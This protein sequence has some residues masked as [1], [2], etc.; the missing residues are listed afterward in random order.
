MEQ[1]PGTDLLL[2]MDK[3]F[4]RSLD[5][6]F[7]YVKALYSAE[8]WALPRMEQVDWYDL[9]VKVQRITEDK[10]VEVESVHTFVDHDKALVFGARK[11][12][13]KG[14]SCIITGND[15][16]IYVLARVR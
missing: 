4:K 16:L 10:K 8:G 5:Q 12:W 6:S 7:G 3:S 11:L 13:N 14:R 1:S 2:Y 15:G 9:T